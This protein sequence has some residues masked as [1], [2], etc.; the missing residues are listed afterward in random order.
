MHSNKITLKQDLTAYAFILPTF[1]GFL[2]FMVYPLFNS[3]Y[4]SFMDWNMFLGREGSEFV[5]LEHFRE[6][7]ENEYFKAGMIN[8]FKLA[9]MAVPL[10]IALSLFLAVL[11]NQDIFGRGI[12]RTMYFMPYVATITA[13]AV[14][15]SAVFHYQ[16]G[17]VN[18][19]LRGIGIAN[20]PGWTA[21]I[22]WALPT[23][24]L[25]WVWKNI[26]YCVVIF[27]AGLQGISNTYY[28]AATIDGAN[29][30]QQFWHIT[31]P[32]VS[33]TTFFLTI[34]NIILSFQIFAEVNVMTKGGP[35]TATYTTV[36]HIF[37]QAFDKFNLGYASAVSWLFFLVIV[38][39]TIIQWLGQHKWVKYV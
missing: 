10:L 11:L 31:M 39:I 7:F 20:P 35:G 30:V 33:P 2:L 16:W 8:N 17:P 6:A 21:S 5:G 22:K 28:E 37:D 27:L 15:F 23:I 12:L 19:F 13:A 14:V 4:L 32:L 25:F 18:N 38:V 9:V 34:T 3:L 29:K 36:F 1:L 26:G 24:A